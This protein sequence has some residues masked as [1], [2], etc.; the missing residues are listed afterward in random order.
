MTYMLNKK[1]FI[2]LTVRGGGLP[3]LVALGLP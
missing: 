2:A 1:Q 3:E